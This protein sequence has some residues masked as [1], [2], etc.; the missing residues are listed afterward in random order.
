VSPVLR[1]K[2]LTARAPRLGSRQMQATKATPAQAASAMSGALSDTLNRVP[3]D[4]M[5]KS[6]LK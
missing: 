2:S 3:A 4:S 6:F 5:L 1:M